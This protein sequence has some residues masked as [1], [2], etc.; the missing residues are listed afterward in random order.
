MNPVSLA[1]AYLAERPLATLLITLLLALGVGTISALLSFDHQFRD[2]LLREARDVH[3]VVGSKGSR[4]Q[5]VLSTV[6]HVDYPTGNIP[7]NE[8]A[9]L[10]DH[11]AVSRAVPVSLGDSVGPFRVVGT[12]GIF[13]EAQGAHLA[14]G[15]I[16]DGSF[17]AVLGATVARELG[18]DVGNVFATTHGVVDGGP[19]HVHDNY[20]VT[21]VLAP[22]GGVADRLVLTSLESIWEVHDQRVPTAGDGR[23]P[24]G[25]GDS[26]GKDEGQSGDRRAQARNA[27]DRD[28]AEAEITALLLRFHSPVSMLRLA[29]EID[30]H[31]AMITASPAVEI[32][33]LFALLAP[34]L[35]VLRG[36]GIVLMAGAA[37]AVFTTLTGA[38]ELRQRDIAILRALGAVRTWTAGVLVAEALILTLAGTL[39]GFALGHGALAIIGSV[40]PEAGNAGLSG[41]VAAPGEAWLFLAALLTGLVSAGVPLLRAS[42]GNLSEILARN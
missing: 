6:L 17:E 31:S 2:R 22:T 42:H 9:P 16:W 1:C 27:R 15:R 39:L 8:A 13:L 21:G 12:T 41:L 35:D 20:T 32:G 33:R 34:A 7:W 26:A 4:L 5:L 10:L 36:F 29:P 3:L 40:I 19:E 28:M 30:R 37:L 18:L 24:G 38:L 11:P 14:K 25:G 23:A